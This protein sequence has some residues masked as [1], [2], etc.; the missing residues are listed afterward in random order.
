MAT[1]S[2]TDQW[3]AI[4]DGTTATGLGS[5]GLL[6]RFAHGRD[7]A[8]FEAIVQH[9]GPMVLAT[10]RRV[11]PDPADADDA[12]QATFL[13]LAR[14]ARAIRDPDRLAPWLHQVAHRV[15]LRA[16]ARSARRRRVEGAG[17]GDLVVAP[18]PA[19]AHELRT[20]LDEELARLPAK[21]RD[22]LVLCYLEGLT[23]DEAASQLDWPVGT[24][25][26]R[27]AG[28][29]DRLRSRLTRRGFAPGAL[30]VL[31]P[32]PWPLAVVSRA[33][34]VATARL[35]LTGGT[36][37]IP[38]TAFLLAQGVLTTMFLAKVQTAAIATLAV[39]AALTAGTVGVVIARQETATQP[40]PATALPPPV[41]ES[42]LANPTTKPTPPPDLSS[43]PT[44]L[45]VAIVKIKALEAAV[46][47]L[48]GRPA[49][50]PAAGSYGFPGRFVAGKPEPPAQTDAPISPAAEDQPDEARLRALKAESA[51]LA[52]KA[53]QANFDLDRLK[54]S[55]AA[56]T[57][58]IKA[59]EETL[60]K[61]VAPIDALKAQTPAD[62]NLRPGVAPK[63]VD[64]PRDP[65]PEP[66]PEPTPTVETLKGSPTIL[67]VTSAAR[68]RVTMINPETQKRATLRLD[69]PARSIRAVPNLSELPGTRGDKDQEL[70]ES[71][72]GLKIE[73]DQITKAAVF[74]RRAMRWFEHDLPR[75]TVYL[76]EDTG[77]FSTLVAFNPV[78]AEPIDELFVFD[79][80][81]QTWPTVKLPEP[82]RGYIRSD[83]SLD[84]TV[85]YEAG[86]FVCVYNQPARKWSVLTLKPND[87]HRDFEAQAVGGPMFIRR[88]PDGKL[89][90]PDGNLIHLYNAKTAE[91]TEINTL[92]DQ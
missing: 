33:L 60:K 16:R 1:T 50:G 7:P 79:A 51:A 49:P 69:H 56:K 75:S 78:Y 76:D 3:G 48:Q 61:R 89:Y 58:E 9:H 90:V 67:M 55:M 38:S 68:D 57:A 84:K 88:F 22:P 10:C 36:K 13:V 19:D 86:R 32:S 11:L 70:I 35:V 65:Q 31:G 26:S 12:F 6:E 29:R 39:A 71:L 14:Q 52:K 20:V 77:L 44:D 53:E 18:D 23:H 72:V 73:G 25:R 42:T 28:G 54:E 87:P 80:K 4:W 8:S 92:D 27:L 81:D 66:M 34:L 82:V 46:A 24:V 15:A 83:V 74:D 63:Q 30:A 59:L 37:G 85:C 5:A 2:E 62:P 17:R 21:Y 91:W 40:K 47:A 43:R 45:E 64:K 41:P